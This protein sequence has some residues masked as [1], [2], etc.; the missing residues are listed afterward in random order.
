MDNDIII[1]RCQEVT[2]QEILDAIADGAV[3]VDGVKRRTRAGMGLCQGKT[4]QR[5]VAKLIAEQTG[6]P[7]A[8][9]LPP[10]SRMPVRP[11]KIGIIGG[12]RDE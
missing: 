3:T 11:V 4:C 5:L 6:R 9:I 7:M 2:K 10:T 8:E 1:C 12:A